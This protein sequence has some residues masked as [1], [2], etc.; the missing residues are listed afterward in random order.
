MSHIQRKHLPTYAVTT[1]FP[2]LDKLTEIRNS[3]VQ[4]GV[5]VG[6]QKSEPKFTGP[7]TIMA[8]YSAWRLKKPPYTCRRVVARIESPK[9]QSCAGDSFQLEGDDAWRP[10]LKKKN[11]LS[12]KSINVYTV[13]DL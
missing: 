7:R 12:R 13:L 10:G 4:Q 3:R 8:Q 1:Y 2:H 5:M 6:E 11:A 9:S